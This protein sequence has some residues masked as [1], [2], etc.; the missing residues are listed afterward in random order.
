MSGGHAGWE[1]VSKQLMGQNAEPEGNR[2]EGRSWVTQ[3]R[4]ENLGEGKPAPE[5]R[6]NGRVRMRNE[7]DPR[8]GARRGESWNPRWG[9]HSQGPSTYPEEIAG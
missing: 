4:P 3:R 5:A 6:R 1:L 2:H 9:G 8:E 7:G